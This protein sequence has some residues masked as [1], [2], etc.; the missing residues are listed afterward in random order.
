MVPDRQAYQL[1]HQGALA[2]SRMEANGLRIDVEYLD[3]VTAETEAEV[4][5]L[6]ARLRGDPVYERWRRRF[7]RKMSLGNHEQLARVL[8]DEMGYENRGFT[9]KAGK[10]KADESSFAHVDLPFVRDYFRVEKLKKLLGTYLKGIKRE[11]VGGYVHPFFHLHKVTTYRSS[12]S[13][14]NVHNQ[15]N[16]DPALA[17]LL[18]RCYVA[19]PG[20]RL[21]EADFGALEFKIACAFWA[22]PGMLDYARDESKDIHKDMA[23][24]LFACDRRQVSKAMRQE[25]KNKFVFPVLYGS[26]YVSC[27]RNLWGAVADPSLSLADGTPVAEHLRRQGVEGPGALDP[28]KTPLPGTYEYHVCRVE[29]EFMAQF[30][31][32]AEKK[33]R[34]IR[35]YQEAGCFKTPTG[36]VCRGAKSRNFLLNAPVQGGGFHC[37]LWSIVQVQRWLLRNA[38]E[39]LLVSQ[40]HDC[41][42]L[43]AV[44]GELQAVLDKV[45]SVM[46][47]EVRGH[48]DWLVVPLTVEVDVTPVDGSWADKEPWHKEGGVW[49]PRPKR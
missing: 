35:D 7:G 4:A 3:R 28:R 15:M 6:T 21:V 45:E 40:V 1:L 5:A 34:W 46:T 8:F 13:D 43:D 9:E 44:E 26:Y 20:R 32:F 31:T 14:P 48:W 17:A 39:T 16:R 11:V 47:R 25:A 12:A 36:F 2:L 42:I 24:K 19:R 29:R 22:D 10:Y 23:A 49:R 27:A 37:M 33:D 38:M 18:R 30:P 41:M